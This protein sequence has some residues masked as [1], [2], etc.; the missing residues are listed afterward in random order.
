L[1]GRVLSHRLNAPDAKV[2]QVV[3]DNGVEKIIDNGVEKTFFC[4]YNWLS[5]LNPFSVL[6]QYS[7]GS[8]LQPLFFFLLTFLESRLNPK[9]CKEKK[10]ANVFFACPYELWLT[11]S[12]A[13]RLR[14]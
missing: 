5:R 14:G 12:G 1:G 9:T 8:P 6:S 2:T 13:R 10:I 4:S 7:P 11:A 3:R